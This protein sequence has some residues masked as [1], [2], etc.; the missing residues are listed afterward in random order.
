MKTI[1][2]TIAFIF[3]VFGCVQYNDSDW[4]VWMPA[5]F[6]VSAFFIKPEIAKK[7]VVLLLPLIG[8]TLWTLSYVPAF[9]AWIKTG[10]PTITGSMKAENPE[11][12]LMREFFGLCLCILGLLYIRSRLHKVK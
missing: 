12:E 7:E 10:T 9:V 11:V 8:F 6:V 3:I 5:Y 4:Y 1:N 2:Y